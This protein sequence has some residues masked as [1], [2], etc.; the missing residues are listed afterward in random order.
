MEYLLNIDKIR[1]H[2]LI[3]KLPIKN[4]NIK[5]KYYYKLL[6]SDINIHL[7]YILIQIKFQQSYV[8]HHEHF[9]KMKVSKEDPFFDKIRSLEQTIL[10]S[11][12]HTL[13]KKIIYGCYHDIM[14]K[15]ILFQSPHSSNY[16][17]MYLKISGI[18]EDEENIGLV[19]KFYHM[20]STEKLSNMIC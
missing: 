11:L 15:D 4:Q 1:S 10:T 20:M 8:E 7:K 12:N 19:Y 2:H 18:W 13:Q 3:F 6:Y 16:Q 17:D 5:Y 14:S 9:Y